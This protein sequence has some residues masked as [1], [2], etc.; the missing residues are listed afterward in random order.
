MKEVLK[1]RF[2]L[3]GRN[4]TQPRADPKCEREGN[5][6][7]R[8]RTGGYEKE[9]YIDF[10]YPS[11]VRWALIIRMNRYTYIRK[12]NNTLARPPIGT[13]IGYIRR[14]PFSRASRGRMN[15]PGERE[16]LH[17]TER[18]RE[19]N[20]PREARPLDQ[21]SIREGPHSNNKK[22]SAF[23]HSDREGKARR[24]TTERTLSLG[25]HS[26]EREREKAC[27]HSEHREACDQICMIRVRPREGV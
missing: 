19:G 17:S 4:R 20:R 5:A 10:A 22:G 14:G 12:D 1:L 21:P 15:N 26:T 11:R 27:L 9:M 7:V 23:S 18:E 25:R 24:Y 3:R 8:G 16:Q 6:A 13:P 2:H